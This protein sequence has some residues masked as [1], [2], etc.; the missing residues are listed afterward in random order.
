MMGHTG[1]QGSAAAFLLNSFTYFAYSGDFGYQ[2]NAGERTAERTFCHRRVPGRASFPEKA[3]G[4]RAAFGFELLS[5]GRGGKEHPAGSGGPGQPGG[6]RGRPSLPAV[7]HRCALGEGVC[8]DS[9]LKGPDG[10]EWAPFSYQSGTYQVFI[11][12]DCGNPDA[13]FRFLDAMSE[14]EMS[15]TMRFGKKDVNWRYA[16]GEAA[17]AG[18]ARNIRPFTSRALIRRKPCPDNGECRH[19]A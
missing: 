7:R 19:L 4:R 15:L 9:S 18:S 16:E 13:A 2:L 14:T 17:T 5:N 1:R 3:G 11:T 8:G 6:R 12:G 10:V